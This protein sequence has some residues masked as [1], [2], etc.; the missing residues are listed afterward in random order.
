M[1]KNIKML[2]LVSLTIVACT[3]KEDE[4][5]VNNSS[6]GLPLTAGTADFSNYVA[7][8]NSLS[9]GFSDGA[10]FIEGQKTSWTNILSQQFALVGGGEFKIPFMKDNVGGFLSGTSQNLNYIPRLYYNT[11]AQP[12][13]APAVLPMMSSADNSTVLTGK[14]N[15]MGVPGAKVFH[16][17]IA[18]Y[19]FANPYF[20]RFASTPMASIIG[21]AVAQEPTFFSLW[22]GNNDVL[23]YATTGG[24]GV[25][26]LGDTNALGYG[27][28]DITDP[29]LFAGAYSQLLSDQTGLRKKN[30]KGVVANIPY[31]TSVP[32]FTFISPTKQLPGFPAD[33][34]ALL[35]QLF[36]GI[37]QITTQLTQPNRFATLIADDGNVAT[38]ENNPILIS[39]ETLTDLAPYIT[40]ALTSTYG[41][42]LAAEIGQ[43]LGKARHARNTTGDR[44][45]ILLSSGSVIN[46][47]INNPANPNTTVTVVPSTP[48]FD[49]FK[50][51]GISYPLLDRHVLTADETSKV[52]TAT[53]SFNASIKGLATQ[54]GLAFVDANKVLNDVATTGVSSNGFTVKSNY[55]TGGGFSLD[56]VHP[57][58]RGYALI[59]NE[60][61]KSINEKYGSN[62]KGVDIGNYRILFPKNL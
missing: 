57:S 23:S 16:L 53:D 14:Y 46:Q 54:Y 33:K 30:S 45:Y 22:I 62:L 34:V 56:G 44:D 41:P 55:V 21:D 31:V 48:I 50:T 6:D 5:V 27:I 19:G 35:N 32:F 7:V 37:N 13:A 1:I 58:P 15:N 61:I 28:N 29:T 17:G 49:S 4:V 42:T 38:V 39:D 43:I 40:G 60:F 24:T 8:G 9:A 25:D 3:T 20:G 51:L 36:G 10:L 11:L 26:R 59:A 47:T 12:S 2:L 52:K 18:G